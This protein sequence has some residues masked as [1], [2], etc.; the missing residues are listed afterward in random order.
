MHVLHVGPRGGAHEGFRAFWSQASDLVGTTEILE[1]DPAVPF[2]Q[3]QDLLRWY[4][5]KSVIDLLVLHWDQ[6]ISAGIW[7]TTSSRTNVVVH[8]YSPTV[9]SPDT[10]SRISS[11]RVCAFVVPTAGA[12]L[13]VEAAGIKKKKIHPMWMPSGQTTA[14]ELEPVIG[15]FAESGSSRTA[16]RL[17]KHMK[18]HDGP[19]VKIF[20]SLPVTSAVLLDISGHPAVVADALSQGTRVLLPDTELN[21]VVYNDSVRYYTETSLPDAALRALGAEPPAVKAAETEELAK[22]YRESIQ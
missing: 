14:E 21:R 16:S 15:V 5:K 17:Q 11:A 4:M 8:R 2:R 12:S 22:L 20:T 19:E 10:V 13:L 3:L 1:V 6:G 7:A 9:L 18:R